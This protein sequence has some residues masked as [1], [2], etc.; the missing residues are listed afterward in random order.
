MSIFFT[1]KNINL[2]YYFPKTIKPNI[3]NTHTHAPRNHCRHSTLF[4]KQNIYKKNSK[5][6]GWVYTR[7]EYTKKTLQ[8]LFLLYRVMLATLENMVTQEEMVVV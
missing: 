6:I 7:I 4:K 2:T 1:L 3:N 8:C 5:L